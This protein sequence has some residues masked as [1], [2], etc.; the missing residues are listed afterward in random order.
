MTLWRTGDRGDKYLVWCERPEPADI[1]A[2]PHSQEGIM[3][4]VDDCFDHNWR[5]ITARRTIEWGPLNVDTG[6]NASI[7]YRFEAT[8]TGGEK[9]VLTWVFTF[10]P[11]GGL[12]SLRDVS[13]GN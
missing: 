7:S 11:N 4:L 6:K 10:A 5:D 3:R 1:G 8:I 13:N 12:L 9:K 2:S